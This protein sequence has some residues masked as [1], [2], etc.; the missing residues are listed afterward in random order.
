MAGILNTSCTDTIFHSKFS[1]DHMATIYILEIFG[2]HG[3]E[4]TITSNPV[5]WIGCNHALSHSVSL[6]NRIRE[7]RLDLLVQDGQHW[8]NAVNTVM[9]HDG[10]IK[11]GEFLD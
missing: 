10:S 11:G 3:S 4:Y 6:I 7:C 8:K 2:S 5:P 9:E 1:P